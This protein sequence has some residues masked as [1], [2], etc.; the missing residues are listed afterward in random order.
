MSLPDGQTLCA[1]LPRD[2]ADQLSEG[3]DAI[4]CF[5]A[6]HVILATLR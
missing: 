2:Q 5:N 6:D 3:S 1:T 4:A